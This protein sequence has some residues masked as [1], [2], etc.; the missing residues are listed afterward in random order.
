MYVKNNGVWT[1][2]HKISV[3]D[4]GL[5]KPAKEVWCKYGGVWYKVYESIPI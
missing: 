2:V 4:S 1:H 5:W 3:K